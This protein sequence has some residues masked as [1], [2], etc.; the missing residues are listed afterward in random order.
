VELERPDGL[1]LRICHG[2]DAAAL[3]AVVRA[4]VEGGRCSN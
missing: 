1:R 4:F 3:D 2:V